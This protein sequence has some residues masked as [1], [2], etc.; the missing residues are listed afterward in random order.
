M[1][2]N[3]VSSL[4]RVEAI[5]RNVAIYELA[6]LVP[7]REPGDNGRPRDFPDYMLLLFDALISVYGSARKV[8]AELSHRYIWKIIRR[9]VKKQ[10]P[11]DPSMHLPAYRY[12]RHHYEYGR[13]RY[14][15]DPVILAQLQELHRALAAEQA[16]E[17]GL[18]DPSGEG[19]FTHPSLDRLLY[20]DGKVVAPLYKATPGTTRVNKETG[21]IKSVRLRSRCRLTFPG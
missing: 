20:A 9:L 13:N 16:R 1:N 5:I 14:L 18:F 12:K 21:E 2:N 3:G 19:S 7:Q 10:F 11:N 8:E 17:L 15:T 4:D 6:K